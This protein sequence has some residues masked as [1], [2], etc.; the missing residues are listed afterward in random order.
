MMD[1]MISFP[2]CLPPVDP[3]GTR[4]AIERLVGVWWVENPRLEDLGAAV[5]ALAGLHVADLV[6][7]AHEPGGTDCLLSLISAA[8]GVG[9]EL[10]AIA[11]G[12]ATALDRAGMATLWRLD[13]AAVERW[14]EA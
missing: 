3:A 14:L 9:E 7:L 11:A 8:S 1:Q 13:P 4:A 12:C 2:P 10:S 5:R 6:A